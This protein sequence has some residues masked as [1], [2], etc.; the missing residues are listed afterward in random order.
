LLCQVVQLTVINLPR[1]EISRLGRKSFEAQ[2]SAAARSETFARQ[3]HI[4]MS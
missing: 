3:I 4:V 2:H 1:F